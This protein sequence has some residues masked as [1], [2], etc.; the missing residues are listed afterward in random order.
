MAIR[1][2]RRG[3]NGSN[4]TVRFSR[5]SPQTNPLHAK[6]CALAHQG[7]SLKCIVEQINEMF[8]AGI[9]N[10]AVTLNQ[11]K[12]VI[13]H[14]DSLVRITP[15][16]VGATAYAQQILNQVKQRTPSAVRQAVMGL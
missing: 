11:V 12:D 3:R 15:H 1:N 16:R 7:F 4:T 8:S 14:P 5:I 6:I 13:Y 2:R 9:F 10:Q